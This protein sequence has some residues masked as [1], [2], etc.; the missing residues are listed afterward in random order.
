MLCLLLS[1]SQCTL[2]TDDDL[3]LEGIECSNEAEFRAYYVL[4]HLRTT[5]PQTLLNTRP[6]V[7]HSEPVQFALRVDLDF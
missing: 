3:Y 4:T 5:G 2:E 1:F 6:A 7:Y